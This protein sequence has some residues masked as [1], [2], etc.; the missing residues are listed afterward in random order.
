[1]VCSIELNCSWNKWLVITGGDY[2]EGLSNPKVEQAFERSVVA[3]CAV[4]VK[5]CIIAMEHWIANG[6]LLKGDANALYADLGLPERSRWRQGPRRQVRYPEPPRYRHPRLS[7]LRQTGRDVR[8]GRSD[9][10][11]AGYMEQIKLVNANAADVYR[12][13]NFDQIPE[14]V[15]QAATVEM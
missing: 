13:M 14:F 6:T 5:R 8:P 7:R 1:M 4:A 3:V 2:G 11:R 12:Y 9:R 10:D 15:E